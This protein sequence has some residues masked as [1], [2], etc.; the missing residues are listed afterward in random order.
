VVCTD[1][2]SESFGRIL[3]TND[4]G[5]EK[6]FNNA[7]PWIPREKI[8]WVEARLLNS[9]LDQGA[10]VQRAPSSVLKRSVGIPR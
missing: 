4:L 9:K 2:G 1:G 10:H 7:S 8:G 5:R 6:L 3:V